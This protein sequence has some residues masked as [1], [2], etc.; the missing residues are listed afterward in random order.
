M[1]YSGAGAKQ[2]A[3]APLFRG[4]CN[5]SFLTIDADHVDDV[6]MHLLKDKWKTKCQGVGKEPIVSFSKKAGL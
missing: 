5:L 1:T 3:I 4:A 2:C 6:D